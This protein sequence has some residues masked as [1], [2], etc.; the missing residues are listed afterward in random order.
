MKNIEIS[1]GSFC[2]LL[3]AIA[4]WVESYFLVATAVLL[5]F[6][7]ECIPYVSHFWGGIFEKIQGFLGRIISVLFL[8]IFYYL[9]FTPFSI[10]QR[11]F[12]SSSALSFKKNDSNTMFVSVEKNYG[13]DTFTNPY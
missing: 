11:L 9:V 1:Y 8:G 7:G 3:V 2:I 6:L 13:P 12:R 10:L 5:A 4:F